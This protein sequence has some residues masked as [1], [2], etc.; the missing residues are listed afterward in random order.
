M[1]LGGTSQRQIAV[2]LHISRNTVKKYW[3][4]DSVPWERKVY[5][6]ETSVLTE[7][8][9]AFVRSCLDEDAQCKSRKQHHI[10]K[11]IYDRLV[12]ECGFTGG[13]TTVRRRLKAAG[14][15]YLK[16][17]E[18]FDCSQL[19]DAVSPLFLQELAS[20]QFV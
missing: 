8:I 1:R 7:D 11:R 6:R 5:I 20:S 14:F 10:A 9:V 4:G 3:D 19:N 15:P 16:T 17:M 18:E 13:E 12:S 2:T